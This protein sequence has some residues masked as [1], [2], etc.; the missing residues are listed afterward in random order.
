MFLFGPEIR[1]QLRLRVAQ[2]AAAREMAAAILARSATMLGE[3]GISLQYELGRQV[4]LPTTRRFADRVQYLIVAWLLTGE[5][6]FAKRVVEDLMVVAGFPDWNRTHFLD[7]AEMVS[8]VAMARQWTAPILSSEQISSVDRAIVEKG[9]VPAEESLRGGSEWT[10]TAG[11][12]NI[13]CN[14]ALILAAL[15]MLET[16]PEISGKVL[17]RAQ[18]SLS[19]GMNAV[20]PSGEWFEGLTYWSYAAHHAALAQI[21]VDQSGYSLTNTALFHP[22][23]DGGAFAAA[24]VAPSGL[25]ANFGDTLS[26]PEH[27]PMQAWLSARNGRKLP[28]PMADDHPFELI[29]GRED[30]PNPALPKAFVGMRLVTLRLQKQLAWLAVSVG[31]AD[32]AHAHHDLGSFIWETGGVRFVVDPGRLDYALKGYFSAGRFGNVGASSAAHNLPVVD[33]ASMLGWRA[34]VKNCAD[35][36]Q[37]IDLTIRSA[38]PTGSPVI[39]RRFQL[40]NDG[41]LQL[42]D[43]ISADPRAGGQK[44]WRW[45]FHTDAHVEK[46]GDYLLLRKLGQNVKVSAVA[47]GRGPWDVHALDN[48]SLGLVD[49]G[50]LM[51]AAFDLPE[52][53]AGTA[54]VVRF[55]QVGR[56]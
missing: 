51:C 42:D 55:D 39:T 10:T 24:S 25:G 29:W 56:D 45:Q 54:A 5:A 20:S 19:V 46:D 14:S 1:Q 4:L 30:L 3:D 21:A 52:G 23:L 22:I 15:T 49:A 37:G 17:Q 40:L 12:W 2:S 28:E 35:T 31:S 9:L 33:P 26:R 16:N 27:C 11:N 8:A 48:K 32:H 7:V 13:V 34:D 41:A 38:A 44:P 6:R 50:N 47:A 43:W 53:A 18:A 36:D